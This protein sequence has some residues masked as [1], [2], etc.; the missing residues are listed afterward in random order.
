MRALL[1]LLL[2]LRQEGLSE[3][4][5]KD[6]RAKLQPCKGEKDEIWRTI[7]WQISITKAR[8]LALKENKPMYVLAPV[9]SLLGST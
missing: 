2:C 6:L 7:P 5:F 9:G 3:E 4:E 1:T 8:Q